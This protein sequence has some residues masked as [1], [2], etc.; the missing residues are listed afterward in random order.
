MGIFGSRQPNE[1]DQKTQERAKSDWTHFLAPEAASILRTVLESAYKHR[2]AYFKAEDIKNAQLWS[3]MLELKKE[4]AEMNRK[5][6]S[7]LPSEKESFRLGMSDGSA[8]METIKNAL[9]PGVEDSNEAKDALV[10][11]LMK[12]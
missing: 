10:E 12:F 11:S 8:A 3:A 1:W 7:L 2:Q 6:D 5:I 4:M 9:K